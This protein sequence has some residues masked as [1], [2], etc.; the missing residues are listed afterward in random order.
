MTDSMDIDSGVLNR[1]EL[2]VNARNVSETKRDPLKSF[3][4]GG[5][6]GMALV[7]VGHPLD[8]IKV[9]MQ[10]NSNS[11][12]L[13]IS[14]AFKTIWNTD[15]LKGFYR[16]M[17]TPFIGVTPIFAVCFWGYDQ[18]HRITKKYYEILDASSPL[19]TGKLRE[20]IFS[21]QLKAAM[22]AGGFSALPTTL[23]M[24]PSERIK[25]LLQIQTAGSE[26]YKGPLDVARKIGLRNLYKGTVATLAR[27]VPGSIAYFAAY[28][29]AKHY[30]IIAQQKKTEYT[31]KSLSLPIGSILLAGGLAGWAN[32]IVAIPAD[33][34]KSRLQADTQNRSGLTIL[35]ELLHQDGLSA[36]FRGLGP[37]LVRSFPAN[38]ACF[39]GVEA[40]LALM[41]RL[42]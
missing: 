29:A 25:V 39:L 11:A 6:G 13:T 18:G 31:E 2:T 33:V 19:N 40:S 23:I 24:T 28:E 26:I 35:K 7:L 5:F 34:I 12:T 15:G 4:S 32:W 21:Y 42:W 9:R 10:T 1:Q 20:E 3:L 17:M 36:L 22:F 27:D 8:L 30:M 37:A 41:H 16:G 38:A 14:S